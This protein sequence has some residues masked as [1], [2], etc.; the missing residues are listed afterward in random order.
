MSPQVLCKLEL[1]CP[2]LQI[3]HQKESRRKEG[4]KDGWT[5]KRKG[6]CGRM[7]FL[8][9]LQELGPA[10]IFPVRGIPVQPQLRHQQCEAVVPGS[11]PEPCS[12]S[13]CC[14]YCA[15]TALGWD[16]TGL[17]CP[18][19]GLKPFVCFPWQERHLCLLTPV[20][21]PKESFPLL[22]PCQLSQGGF[23]RTFPRDLA[24]L[25]CSWWPHGLIVLL[26]PL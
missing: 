17:H 25:L 21:S 16:R 10:G 26:S 4:R 14:R 22:M 13:L 3:P 24:A 15:A 8:S 5:R 18:C 2:H 12:P 7:W 9:R 11:G 19:A 20:T 23:P 1:T 6:K